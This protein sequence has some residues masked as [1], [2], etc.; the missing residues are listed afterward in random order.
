M[1]YVIAV[2]DIGE[3]RVNKVKKVF[4]QYMDWIQ[5]SVFE[6]NLTKSELKEI[7]NDLSTIMNKNHDSVIFFKLRSEDAMNKEIIGQE[8]NPTDRII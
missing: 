1:L 5:N 6:G 3:E 8:K 4:R 7:K 2:Y